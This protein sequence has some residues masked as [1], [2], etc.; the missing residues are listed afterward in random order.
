[1]GKNFFKEINLT[2]KVLHMGDICTI[3]EKGGCFEQRR[4]G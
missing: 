2:K 3:I 1:M 4:G